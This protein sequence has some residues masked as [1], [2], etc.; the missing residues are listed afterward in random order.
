MEIRDLSLRD[1]ISLEKNATFPLQ[2][3]FGKLFIIRKSI[4]QDDELIG[5]FLVKLTTESMLVFNDPSPITRAKAL[6]LMYDYI[7]K[8]LVKLGFDDNH[9]FLNNLEQYGELLKKHFGFE[10]VIGKPLV[11]RKRA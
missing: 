7:C 11:I 6:K 8:E 9:V 3:P 5:S 1:L 2:D 10:D 4:I